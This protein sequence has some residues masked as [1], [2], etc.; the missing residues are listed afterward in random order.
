MNISELNGTYRITTIS[1]QN[2][3]IEKRSDGTTDIIDGKTYREDDAGC[4]WRSEMA[5][6]DENSVQF[7]STADPSNA[8]DDFCLIDAHG[9][10]TRAEVIYEAVLN[11]ARKGDK[12][13][14]SGQIDHGTETIVITMIKQS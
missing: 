6:I 1:D 13:K 9:D 10:L 14:I 5:F 4:V 8:S 12:V 7:I 11:I 3:P 2:G